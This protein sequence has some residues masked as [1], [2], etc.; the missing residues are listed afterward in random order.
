MVKK[1]KSDSEW[2]WKYFIWCFNFGLSI[3]NLIAYDGF[4][5]ILW[6]LMFMISCFM[7]SANIYSLKK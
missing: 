7:L 5:K 6:F 2:F 1:F 3:N 4:L